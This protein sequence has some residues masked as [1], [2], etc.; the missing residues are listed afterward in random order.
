MCSGMA[1]EKT[2]AY[3]FFVRDTPL[4]LSAYLV[5]FLFG[6]V[7]FFVLGNSIPDAL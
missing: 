7:L 3:P 4:F 1:K 6:S 2:A 5:P